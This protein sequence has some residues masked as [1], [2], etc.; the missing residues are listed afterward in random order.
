MYIILSINLYYYD[1]NNN[2]IKQKSEKVIT[3]YNTTMEQ[4][5]ETA[6]KPSELNFEYSID[7]DT[8]R[9]KTT[10]GKIAWYESQGYNWQNFPH[11]N[12][13]DTAKLKSGEITYSDDDINKLV[14]DEYSEESYS[15]T[16]EYLKNEWVNLAEIFKSQL[17]ECS[18][19]TVDDYKIVLT[20][21]GSGGSYNIPDTVILNLNVKNK[22][23][24]NFFITMIHEMIHLSI[25]E[26]IR[27]Y[28][29]SQW[30]KERIVDL[31]LAQFFPDMKR[32]QNSRLDTNELEIIDNIYDKGYNNIEE[33]IKQVGELNKK[34]D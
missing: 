22:T 6:E 13:I 11:P 25:E 15:K 5:I 18:L 8:Q 4:K 34:E 32:F 3:C 33:I 7:H 21:Y 9:V 24:R 28:R 31:T 27:K 29:L 2:M 1:I 20:K 14:S 30:Q 19:P 12:G 10:L 26:L 16:A 23:E 17:K